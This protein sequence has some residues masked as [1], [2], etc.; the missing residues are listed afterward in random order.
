[1]NLIKNK[2][3]SG[4]GSR[5]LDLLSRFFKGELVDLSENAPN[6]SSILLPKP[7]PSNSNEKP[8]LMPILKK[9][10]EVRSPVLDYLGVS[11]GLTGEL[12]RFWAKNGF[13]CLYIRQ[14]RNDVTAEHSCIMIKQLRCDCCEGKK[15]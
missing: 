5:A 10:T 2:T 8:K 6:L 3:I 7:E 15:V 1:M 14:T 4:Y 11:F 12:F 9:L 13:E